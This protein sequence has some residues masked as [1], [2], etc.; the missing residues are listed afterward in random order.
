[1]PPAPDPADSSSSRRRRAAVA[2]LLRSAAISLL[3]L[4]VLAGGFAI[5]WRM[6]PSVTLDPVAIPTTFPTT[7]PTDPTERGIGPGDRPWVDN[8]EAGRLSSKFTARQFTPVGDGNFAVDHPVWVFYLSGEQYLLLIGDSALV[9]VDSAGGSAS[10]SA[11]GQ[12]PGGS[13]GTS[14]ANS[15]D[16]ATISTSFMQM[17]SNGTLQHVQARLFPSADALEPTLTLTTNNMAFDHDTLRLF[18]QGFTDASGHF[19]PAD[20]VPVSVRGDDY[21]FDGQGLSMHWDDRD[22]RLQL[23][24]I[25]HG[26]DLVIKHP[27]KLNTPL[28]PTAA[29]AAGAGRS[30]LPALVDADPRGAGLALAPATNKPAAPPVVYQAVFNEQVRVW[31]GDQ[32][33]ATADTMTVNFLSGGAKPTAGG[34]RSAAASPPP[35]PDEPLETQPPAPLAATRAAGGATPAAEPPTTGPATTPA[36]QPVTVRWVGKLRLTPLDGPPI[37]PLAAGQAAV[38]LV[39]SPVVLTPQ[40]STVRAAAVVYRSGDSAG[41][42]ESSPAVPLVD[43]QQDN[44][45]TF[46]TESASYDPATALATIVGRS[47]L[48]VPLGGPQQAALTASWTHLAKIHVLASA[49]SPQSVDHAEMFGDVKVNHPQFNLKTDQLA[50]DLEPVKQKAPHAKA[51]AGTPDATVTGSPLNLHRMT[52]VGNVICRLPIVYQFQRGIDSDRLVME[53]QTGPDGQAVPHTVVADGSVRAFDQLAEDELRAGHLE[54][55]LAPAPQAGGGAG[56]AAGAAMGATAG[57]AG[58]AGGTAAAAA[59]ADSQSVALQSML[60]TTAVHVS[61]KGGITADA[62]Q[63]RLTTTSEGRQ[64]VELDGAG[65]KL[66][67]VS[68]A[69]RGALSGPT[70]QIDPDRSAV[71]VAGPGT[72]HSDR[73]TSA[74]Q[75]SQPIDVS[76][77]HDMSV[78]ESA[79]TVDLHGHIVANLVDAT[80]DHNQIVGDAVHANLMDAPSPPSSAPDRPAATQASTQPSGKPAKQIHDLAITGHVIASSTLHASDGVTVLRQGVMDADEMDYDAITGQGLV[81]GPGRMLVE[82]HRPRVD[83][84]PGAPPADAT[85]NTRGDLAI[86]WQKSLAYDSANNQ[87][88]FTGDVRTV[89]RQSQKGAERM[90]LTCDR[91][92]ADL[93]KQPPAAGSDAAST[94][95]SAP[96]SARMQLQRVTAAGS[97]RFTAKDLDVTAGQIGYDPGTAQLRAQGTPREPGHFLDAQGQS[98]GNFDQVIYDTASEKIVS[99]Q[100]LSGSVHR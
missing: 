88:V 98:T 55:V 12:K 100:G 6:Q 76:W 75:P 14:A 34:A 45:L 39:G 9:H 60:A 87:I 46:H 47:D 22:G 21:D 81:P 43:V 17:P 27:A 11:I 4:A 15:L 84:A 48:T 90:D 10:G 5:Y 72:L 28:A 30:P 61:R 41:R 77:E 66:A 7:A 49:G 18:T 19:V 35:P 23:L 92:I 8:Y 56:G 99:E 50:L 89:V 68:D 67:S 97:A 96:G 93:V 31:Q 36:Q 95:A 33:L 94:S 2:G 59:G 3:A 38:R 42:L 73:R 24:E 65:D 57:D 82:D 51:S 83:P 37:L 63:L 85:G 13:S 40:G 20:R 16:S 44:G 26:Q 80:G 79:N 74:T 62:D 86:Q 91:L 52:A 71:A 53:T 1:M 25:A 70:I 54:A 69:A 32:Q 64:H 29:A 58:E 78:D